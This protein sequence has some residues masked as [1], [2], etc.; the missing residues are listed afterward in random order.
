[1]YGCIA[2]ILQTSE[3]QAELKRRCRTLSTFYT[4][5]QKHDWC[6]ENVSSS[7]PLN[8]FASWIRNKKIQHNVDAEP[9]HAWVA[10]F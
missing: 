1:M 4:A 10:Y 9:T 6:T 3:R 7:K 5:K 8:S 2:K